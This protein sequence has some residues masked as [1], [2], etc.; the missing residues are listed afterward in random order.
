MYT[1]AAVCDFAL[2]EKGAVSAITNGS[3]QLPG[4]G[5]AEGMCPG[6]RDKTML[7]HRTVRS[8]KDEARCRHANAELKEALQMQDLKANPDPKT[9]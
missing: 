8:L 3:M 7:N 9:P 2:R 5:V 1:L 4:T 6:V